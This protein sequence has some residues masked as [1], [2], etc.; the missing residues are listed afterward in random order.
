MRAGLLFLS[1]SLLAACG[2]KE[3]PGP[4]GSS[5]DDTGVDGG[6]GGDDGGTEDPCSGGTGLGEGDFFIEADGFSAWVLKVP[7]TPACA[8][9]MLFGHGG[10][11]VGAY[12]ENR[13]LDALN[14]GLDGRV[15][16]RGYILVVPFLED[17]AEIT[18][19]TWS[20]EQTDVIDAFVDAL[21]EGAD[22]DTSKVLFVGQSAGG[23]M[24]VYQGLYQ[25]GR[26]THT[27]AVSSGIGAYFD[28]PEPEPSLKLPFFVAHDPQDEVVPYA[29]SEQL[30]ADLDA[31]GHDYVFND[32]T[33]GE[34][35]HR[36]SPELTDALL[37]WWLGPLDG[38]GGE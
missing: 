15:A 12:V 17:K 20:L 27:V 22:I 16:E 3:D 5:T 7:G 6:T 8:P 21:A 24:A 11:N 28:Y 29:Y 35:G 32:Y 34:G 18:E 26:V 9:V 14:T 33:L 37:D 19:H 1:L 30:A 36:W 10:S 38:G 2:D 13:W 4:D 25:P 23:H 31:H